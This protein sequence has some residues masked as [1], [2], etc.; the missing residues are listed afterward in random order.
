MTS[1]ILSQG[2]SSDE[3]LD[4]CIALDRGV[5]L[6]ESW[7]RIS[8]VIWLI[9][10]K[11][12]AGK[13]DSFEL[14][15]EDLHQLAWHCGAVDKSLEE[16]GTVKKYYEVITPWLQAIWQNCDAI[17]ENRGNRQQMTEFLSAWHDLLIRKGVEE[18]DRWRHDKNSL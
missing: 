8:T 12:Q 14:P 7:S 3:L 10:Q 16:Y 11:V 15:L 13:L 6:P 2:V 9:Y 4:I 1:G 18:L 5:N 17:R